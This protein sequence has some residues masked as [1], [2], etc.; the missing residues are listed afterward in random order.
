H[1]SMIL[2]DT[3]FH[4]HA[5]V[6]AGAD[7]S[8]LN[9]TSGMDIGT[10]PHDITE[11]LP[12]IRRFEGIKY[13]IGAGPWCVSNGEDA[14][15]ADMAV[16]E[17][18]EKYSPSFLGEI[19][20]DWYRD[21]EHRSEQIRLFDL[22]LET[23]E[24]YGLPVVIHNRDADDDVIRMLE[25]KKISKGGIIHCF[26]A[27]ESFMKR[28]LDL[29]FMISFSGTLTYKRNSVLR[30]ICRKVPADSILLETDS[31]YLTPEPLRGT[32]NDPEKIIHTYSLAAAVRSTSVEDLAEL[33]G[34]NFKAL[35]AR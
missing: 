2:T 33:V 34:N 27:D 24:E 21:T 11:R 29:G 10:D 32:Q 7:I 9:I 19:G 31:P 22:Q 13:S 30:D 15:A 3:H 4:L 6:R 25:E 20:L 16:R 28:A 5:M 26:S 8:R 12:L 35:L 18:L 14:E 17:D 1:H 23:A